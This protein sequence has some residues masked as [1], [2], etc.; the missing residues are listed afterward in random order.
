MGYKK[1]ITNNRIKL[2]LVFMCLMGVVVLFTE[3]Y[4]KGRGLTGDAM[5]LAGIILAGIATVGRMWCS[6]YISGYKRD[7]LI[8]AGPY[9]ASRNPLYFFSLMGSVGVGLATRTFTIPAAVFIAFTIYYPFIIRKEEG[10]MSFIHG[11][12]F[13][14]YRSSVPRF[15]PSF[16]RF[17]E[18]E[19]YTIKPKY[20]RGRLFDSLWFIWF[21]GI[22]G[23]ISALHDYAVIPVFF[24]LY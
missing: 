5:F 6:I 24:R 20:L 14:K 1:G 3:S 7:V 16:S 9:S 10:R 17:D 15:I 8:T 18:P 12:N 19:T 21:V 22:V 13:D 4:W 23:F 11:E 2:G